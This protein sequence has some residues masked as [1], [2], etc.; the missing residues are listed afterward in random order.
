[1]L[2]ESGLRLVDKHILL[3]GVGNRL[4][5]D[6][7]VGSLLVER[8]QGRVDIPMIDAGDLTIFD[9]DQVER[10]SISTHTANL[11]LLF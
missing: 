9:I 6:D 3:L 11:G 5:G 2:A 4:R 1:M 7:A 10:I 8:L